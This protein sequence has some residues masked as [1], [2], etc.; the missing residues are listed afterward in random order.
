MNEKIKEKLSSHF[1]SFAIPKK[2]LPNLFA[3]NKKWK[4]FKKTIERFI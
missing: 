1:G 2:Y 4:N 3:K